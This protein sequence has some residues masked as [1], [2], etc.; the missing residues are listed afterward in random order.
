MAIWTI[1][2]EG[3]LAVISMDDGKA[4]AHTVP[5]FRSLE[6][7]LDE[8]QAS[9][10]LGVVLTGRP[11]IL[12]GGM[13]L[14]VLGTLSLEEKKALVAAMGSAVL[15]LHLFPKPVVTAVCGHA[16][17]AGAMFGL[18]ADV[19]LFAD[20]PFKF[21]L[22]EVPAGMFVPTFAVE[23]AR[24]VAPQHLTQLVVHGRVLSPA[25]ALALGVAESVHAPEAL[26]PAALARARELTNLTGSGYALTKRLVRGP[27]A[28]HARAV[29]PGELDELARMLD[30]RKPVS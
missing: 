10:A 11:G 14:K 24:S 1:R 7:A 15:K 8:A 3:E 18:A 17:G 22:N 25:E 19:R 28:D 2:R 26:L 27:G 5:E 13:N 29:L 12:S 20:G 9:S 30:T 21:G 16:L 4:N 6:A 23:L